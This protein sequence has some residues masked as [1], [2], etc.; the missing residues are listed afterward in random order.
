MYQ[1]RRQNATNF[2]AFKAI[3]VSAGRF[4][5]CRKSHCRV[6]KKKKHWRLFNL[7]TLG[8]KLH[9]NVYALPFS[10]IYNSS[11]RNA[12]Q[13]RFA[14]LFL[15]LFLMSRVF[16]FSFYFFFFPFSFSSSNSPF[17]P[18]RSSHCLSGRSA[19][20]LP[21]C[22]SCSSSWSCRT[23]LQ[24]RLTLLSSLATIPGIDKLTTSA[25]WQGALFGIGDLC[26]MAFRRSSLTTLCHRALTATLATLSPRI[27]SVAEIV[28]RVQSVCVSASASVCCVL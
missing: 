8:R 23:L 25:R 18:A 28:A 10:S 11:D 24:Q 19:T 27:Q 12:C 14:L 4:T 3:N 2:D 13:R 16:F 17:L 15:E 22:S 7:L 26:L 21:S 1:L 5:S 9:Q 6:E 20:L